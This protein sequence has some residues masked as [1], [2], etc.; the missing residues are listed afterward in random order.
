MTRPRSAEQMSARE[1]RFAPQSWEALRESGNPVYDISREYAVVFPEKIPAELPADRV[2]R[3]KI[4]LVPG[5]KFCVTRQWPLP[6]DQVED[7]DAFFEGRRKAGRV[8]ESVTPH[9]S[10]IFFVKKATEG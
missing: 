7:I 10:P 8:R 5:S 4:D 6:R 3:H 1:E 2:V 9:S